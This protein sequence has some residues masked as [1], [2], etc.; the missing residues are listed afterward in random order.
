MLLAQYLYLF[1]L[2]HLQFNGFLLQLHILLVL[3]GEFSLIQGLQ[4]FGSLDVLILGI[5]EVALVPLFQNLDLLFQCLHLYLLL[6]DL[7]RLL[8]L[9]ISDLSLKLL[10]RLD[11]SL[12]HFR[13]ELLNLHLQLLLGSYLLVDLPSIHHHNIRQKVIHH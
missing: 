5:L 3:N 8:S 11:H 1:N 6:L 9:E 10:L 12:R 13:L 7:L 2:Q 4:I